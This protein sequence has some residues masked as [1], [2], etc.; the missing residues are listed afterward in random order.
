MQA[1]A[2]ALVERNLSRIRRAD[3]IYHTHPDVGYTD[4]PS[5]C[6]V[7]RKRFIDFAVEWRSG[8]HALSRSTERVVPLLLCGGWWPMVT[9]NGT[10]R[11]VEEMERALFRP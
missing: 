7:M 9:I 1:P 10:W 3:L 8:V 5:V 2:A 6:Q 4:L 11:Q